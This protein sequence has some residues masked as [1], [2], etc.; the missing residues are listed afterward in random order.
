MKVPD[1]IVLRL[2]RSFQM[3]IFTK[4]LAAAFY[5]ISYS[6][7]AYAQEI[8]FDASAEPR[9]A[10]GYQ[11]Q[12]DS[13]LQRMIAYRDISDLNLPAIRVLSSSGNKVSLYPLKD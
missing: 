12:W 4:L 13:D 11:L 9:G 10:P 1:V 8:L 5:L 3:S 6:A 2:S 7:V